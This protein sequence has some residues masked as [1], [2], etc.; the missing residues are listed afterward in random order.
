MTP[1]CDDGLDTSSSSCQTMA[2]VNRGLTL[3]S[4]VVDLCRLPSLLVLKG[5]HLEPSMPYLMISQ[6]GGWTQHCLE[7]AKLCKKSD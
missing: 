1:G 5:C 2:K 7:S 3:F 6:S 4:D